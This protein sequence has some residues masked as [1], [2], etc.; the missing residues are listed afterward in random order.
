MNN[1]LLKI[2]EHNNRS[3]GFYE[4]ICLDS[5]YID[6]WNAVKNTFGRNLKSFSDSLDEFLEQ[7]KNYTSLIAYD[8]LYVMEIE[9]EKT[10]IDCKVYHREYYD[11]GITCYCDRYIYNVNNEGNC[12]EDFIRRG[13]ES[14]VDIINELVE[15]IKSRLEQRQMTNEYH[16]TAC[17]EKDFTQISLIKLQAQKILE[18]CNKQLDRISEKYTKL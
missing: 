12:I 4:F 11:K 16:N 9:Y 6:V 2:T 17:Y 3:T 8:Y 14:R 10:I 13:V 15:D 7:N 18:N 5:N 1:L